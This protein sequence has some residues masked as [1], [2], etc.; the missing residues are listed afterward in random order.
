MARLIIVFIALLN[1]ACATLAEIAF[2]TA[3]LYAE[4]QISESSNAYSYTPVD[5]GS[6]YSST[7]SDDCRS[8]GSCRYDI[9]CRSGNGKTDYTSVYKKSRSAAQSYTQ[10]L[11]KNK[12]MF[13]TGGSKS[14]T[15]QLD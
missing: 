7:A 11:A 9:T 15:C 12:E 14:W 5:Y 8:D 4:Q 1:S 13:N 3:D 2:A 6:D 10:G